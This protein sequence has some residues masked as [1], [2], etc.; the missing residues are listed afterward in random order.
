MAS[1]MVGI[2][3]EGG[4]FGDEAWSEYNRL[5]EASD[6]MAEREENQIV[7]AQPR[8]RSPGQLYCRIRRCIAYF[9][10]AF[11]FLLIAG[12][13]E[14][15]SRGLRYECALFRAEFVVG[16]MIVTFGP[17]V[18]SGWSRIDE[19]SSHYNGLLYWTLRTWSSGF[20]VPLIWLGGL[21]LIG[22]LAMLVPEVCSLFRR[23]VEPGHCRKCQYNLTGNVTGICPE[24]G[25]AIQL[26]QATNGFGI[27]GN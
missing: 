10:I 6:R 7:G 8:S 22:F 12:S 5:E 14:T 26:E 2:V 1:D 17:S 18:G 9:G 13:G 16:A 3:I 27:K 23:H 25:T 15:N 4:A 20:A 21:F 11:S 19:V 24:C